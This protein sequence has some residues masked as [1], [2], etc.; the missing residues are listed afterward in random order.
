MSASPPAPATSRIEVRTAAVRERHQAPPLT[1]RADRGLDPGPAPIPPRPVPSGVSGGAAD[2]PVER[3]V[4]SSAAGAGATGGSGP[5]GRAPAASSSLRASRADGLAAGFL[6]RQRWTRKPSGSGS[7]AHGGVGVKNGERR[8]CQR[9]ALE[10]QLT[11]TCEHDRDGPR[12]HVGRCGHSHPGQLLRSHERRSSHGDLAGKARGGHAGNGRQPEVDHHWPVG[13]EQDIAGLEVAVHHPGG[14][15][16]AERGQGRDGNA[17]E[18]GAAARPELLDDLHQRWPA[19]VFTDNERAPFEDSRIQNLG[20]AEPGDPLRRGDLLQKA[21]PDQWV[22]GRRQE[23]DRRPA[24]SGTDSQEHDA[25]PAFTKA[26]EQPVITHLA[27]IHL[28]QGEHFRYCGPRVGH[29]AILPWRLAYVEIRFATPPTCSPLPAAAPPV[30]PYLA[31]G[32]QAVHRPGPGGGACRAGAQQ[33]PEIFNLDTHSRCRVR[34]SRAEVSSC[35]IR[36]SHTGH[37]QGSGCPG[38]AVP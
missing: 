12:P 7:L 32:A 16:C 37:W 27:R 29:Q 8:G 23:L 13:P 21:A 14:M 26:A 19:D 31:R 25:L 6:L 2:V 4:S 18:H 33:R 5:T 10:G 30:Q 3:D 17:L 38:R 24:S 11:G 36:R 20:S 1:C 28:A 22:R 34:G 15:H 35:G 9:L